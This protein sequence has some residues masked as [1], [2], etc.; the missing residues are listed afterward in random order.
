MAQDKRSLHTNAISKR[1]TMPQDHPAIIE[2]K[3]TPQLSCPFAS[4]A[5]EDE[6]Q[7]LDH[8]SSLPRPP[9]SL[10]TPPDTGEHYIIDKQMQSTHSSPVPPPPAAPASVTGSLSKCPIRLLD[11]RPPEEIAEYFETHKHEIP[12]S[13]E[14]CVKR[15]QSNEQSIRQLDAK[16]GNLVNM[17]QGLGMKHQPL[18]P[19]ENEGAELDKDE[20]EKS[21]YKSGEG[22]V[23]DWVGALGP[24]VME[25]TTN[26]DARAILPEREGHFER[27]LKEIRVGES[28]SR[29]W[30]IS[31]PVGTASHVEDI[32]SGQM[33]TEPKQK[34]TTESPSSIDFKPKEGTGV[35]TSK[36]STANVVFSGPVFIGYSPDQ[37]A[38][39]LKQIGMKK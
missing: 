33:G 25:D 39:F 32:L 5:K 37:A 2:Q 17:I 16:Y 12:R 35:Q 31:V 9:D 27:S 13:H 7:P 36:D 30:G 4:F 3:G 20:H 21:I 14:V 10:P 1:R 22:K 28:P 15:Y 19:R 38:E 24:A 26:E 6:L 11:E 34:P 18:L 29:P 23:D 8:L